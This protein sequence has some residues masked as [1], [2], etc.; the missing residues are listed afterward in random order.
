MVFHHAHGRL[1]VQ[2]A[3][4]DARG[5][6]FKTGLSIRSTRHT[7][8]MM[9]TLN[10]VRVGAMVQDSPRLEPVLPHPVEDDIF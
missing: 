1:G 10:W 3:D 9:M 4:W 2:L 5:M 6:G 8:I 7:A